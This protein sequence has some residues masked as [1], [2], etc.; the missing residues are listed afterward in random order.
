MKLINPIP[1]DWNGHFELAHNERGDWYVLAVFMGERRI[2]R[3]EQSF[4][5]AEAVGRTLGGE[6]LMPLVP[7]RSWLAVGWPDRNEV[8]RLGAA[9]D[10]DWEA[11]YVPDELEASLRT[12]DPFRPWRPQWVKERAAG[13][14]EAVS[15]DARFISPDKRVWLEVPFAERQRVKELGAVWHPASKRWFTGPMGARGALAR[16]VP[17]GR[18]ESASCAS[19]TAEKGVFTYPAYLFVPYEDEYLAKSAGVLHSNTLKAW[20]APA[21]SRKEFFRRWSAVR[22]WEWRTK[23]AEAKNA[24]PKPGKTEAELELERIG[25][26]SLAMYLE[27]LR[28]KYGMP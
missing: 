21:G 26:E 5:A 15:E 23:H 6:V 8:K 20:Y 3:R 27:E 25:R 17:Q 28:K 10:P 7:R 13:M 18:A 16:W 11:W 9:Y 2:L 4:E 22:V 24:L 12:E 1:P 14:S 19:E